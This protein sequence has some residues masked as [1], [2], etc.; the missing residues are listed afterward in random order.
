MKSAIEL[1]V[2]QKVK[3]Y[4]DKRNWSQQ[5]LADCINLSASFVSNRENPKTDDAFN[6]DHINILA[7]IF[8]FNFRLQ[9]I[10]KFLLLPVTAQRFP[11]SCHSGLFLYSVTLT[12]FL[13]VT[14]ASEPES[15]LILIP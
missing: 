8:F 3:E 7:K 4:R 1:Y 11:P 12:C 9:N 14:P 6:L 2:S 13:S 15:R 5:Y 10:L